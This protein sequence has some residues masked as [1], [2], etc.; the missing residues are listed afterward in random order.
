MRH[1]SLLHSYIFFSRILSL[2]F[3]MLLDN[4]SMKTEADAPKTMATKIDEAVIP[5]DITAIRYSS[6]ILLSPL[7]DRNLITLRNVS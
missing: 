6:R 7:S 2:R 4:V 1:I 3:F 5:F